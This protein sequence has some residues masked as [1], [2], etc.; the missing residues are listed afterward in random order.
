MKRLKNGAKI[1]LIGWPT[2][3]QNRV[4]EVIW[5]DVESMM[6]KWPDSG[7]TSRLFNFGLNEEGTLWVRGTTIDSADLRAALT[8][9]ALSRA[10]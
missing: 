1:T 9:Q 5:A 7:D 6:L 10:F 2:K 4:F 8:A 3:D